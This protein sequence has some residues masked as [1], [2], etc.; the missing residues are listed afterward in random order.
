MGLILHKQSGRGY[1]ALSKIF[2]LP[3][4]KTIMQLLNRIPINP[5]VND[6]IFNNLAEVVSGLDESS[7]YCAVMFDEMSLDPHIHL[8]VAT[9]EFEGF[10][11]NDDEQR[12]AV[13]ADHA[14]VFMVRGLVKNWKQPLA[15]TFCRS[16]T[17]S[18]ILVRLLTKIITRC[19]QAGLKVICT[20]CG[21][22]CIQESH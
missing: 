5:G 7:K 12:N 19:Q 4:K 20:I 6:V 15:Y 18:V 8:N 22:T 14:L 1:R 13:I 3:S 11:T 17:K 10:E 16:S 2:A 21:N 9:K